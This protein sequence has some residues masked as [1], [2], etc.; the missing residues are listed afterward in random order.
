MSTV[1]NASPVRALLGSLMAGISL[2]LVV[3]GL[4]YAGNA[5]NVFSADVNPVQ[6]LLTWMTDNLRASVYAFAAVLVLFVVLVDRL[7]TLLQLEAPLAQISQVEYLSDLC[8][9]LFFGIGVIW[10]CLLYTSAAAYYLS[11]FC[12]CVLLLRYG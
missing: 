9:S 1:E 4:L 6:H 11:R 10:T 8:T 2:G 3:L 5:V 12:V 7:R